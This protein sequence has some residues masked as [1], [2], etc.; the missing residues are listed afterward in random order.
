[1]PEYATITQTLLEAYRK[2]VAYLRVTQP[3]PPAASYLR[4]LEGFGGR[5][6]EESRVYFADDASIRRVDQE[7]ERELAARI[8]HGIQSTAKGLP[9]MREVILCDAWNETRLRLLKDETIRS[10]LNAFYSSE[11]DPLQYIQN[12]NLND[13][14]S[15]SIEPDNG[16]SHRRRAKGFE[17]F[18]SCVREFD[19]L[20][21]SADLKD[22]TNRYLD[23][24]LGEKAVGIKVAISTAL[25]SLQ[26]AAVETYLERDRAERP[27]WR[28]P[29]QMSQLYLNIGTIGLSGSLA[30]EWPDYLRTSLRLAPPSRGDEE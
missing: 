17:G 1:M 18:L 20:A 27:D 16:E 2:L 14:I 19:E 26:A 4:Q 29:A 23:H 21:I 7:T 5:T 30:Q 13:L 24:V 9:G 22:L 25:G 6:S 3:E 28:R 10:L 15:F 8:L 11:T 12:S